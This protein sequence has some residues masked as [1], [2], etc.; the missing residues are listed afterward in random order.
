MRPRP[1]AQHLCR[2]LYSTLRS[3]VRARVVKGRHLPFGSR[4]QRRLCAFSA[5][6]CPTGT[7]LQGGPPCDQCD[8]AMIEDQP[9]RLPMSVEGSGSCLVLGTHASVLNDMVEQVFSWADSG[10]MS[11]VPVTEGFLAAMARLGLAQ[12]SHATFAGFQ[13]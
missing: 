1:L 12:R 4:F 2:R 6:A 8:V 9:G 7:S 11:D 13:E 5:F 3:L 10:R